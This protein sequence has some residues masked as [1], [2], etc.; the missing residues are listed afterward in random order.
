[1]DC[2]TCPELD[3]DEW[4]TKLLA[5]LEG[6]RYPL[7]GTFELTER[8]NLACVHCYINQP[9]ASQASR[10]RELTTTQIAGV[11]DQLVDAGCLFLLFTGGEALLR[12]DF[13]EIYRLARQ[14]GMLVSLFTNGTL[15]TPRIADLMADLR[16][17]VIEITLYGATEQT[18]ERV[19]QVPGSYKR[20]RQGIE[21]LLDRDLR[22]I[23]KSVLLST[24]RHELAEMRAL[25]DQLGVK[26]RYDGTLWPRLDGGQQPYDYRLSIQEM[27]A[28]DREDPERQQEWAKTAEAFSGQLVRS[29]Y[30]YS[31]GAG[32]R[33]F[34]ID[35]TGRM[36]ICTMSRRPAYDLL[37]TSFQEAWEQLGALR[38]ENGN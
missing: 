14:R 18:Y 4:G 27:V 7:G 11:L 19:T 29:E 8:C 32:L 28:L 16:P 35:S 25:A 10:T 20:C 12:R 38:Q 24:N 37:H 34:H 33:S 17:H 6:C 26:F 31:C 22:L 15:L 30:V 5:P 1:M 2:P 13:S 9:A 23:L 3:L 36:S 21:L